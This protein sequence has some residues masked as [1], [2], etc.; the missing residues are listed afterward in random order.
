MVS[1]CEVRAGRRREKEDQGGRSSFKLLLWSAETCI[2]GGSGARAQ[3][4]IGENSV[5]HL[6]TCPSCWHFCFEVYVCRS[7]GVEEQSQQWCRLYS[8][9]QGSKRRRSSPF[10][11]PQ[12]YRLCLRPQAQ[13]SHTQRA[14]KEV[15]QPASLPPYYFTLRHSA[16][17]VVC[18][19]SLRNLFAPLHAPWPACLMA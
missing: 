16:G 5:A 19:I 4:S 17:I 3:T 15:Q 11:L 12:S 1:I 6:V 14:K 2:S 18:E 8:I 13:R 7:V 10:A 9:V